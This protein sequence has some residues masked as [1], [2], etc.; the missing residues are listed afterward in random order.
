MPSVVIA[1]L[2]MASISFYAG[3]YHL[4]LFMNRR[5]EGQYLPFGLLCLAV[6]MY[7]L[8]A[9]KTKSRL[10]WKPVFDTRAALEASVGWYRKYYSHDTAE[11]KGST[12][13][14]IDDF[15]EAAASKKLLWAQ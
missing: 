1:C 15:V 4:A 10:G 13:R 11:M 14:Q 5:K 8:D 7:G 6:G 3:V 2:V 12:I 9:I